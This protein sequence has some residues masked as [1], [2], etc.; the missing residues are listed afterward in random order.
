M[1]ANELFFLTRTD[2]KNI[3]EFRHCREQG[4]WKQGCRAFHWIRQHSLPRH[5]FLWQRSVQPCVQH[6]QSAHH[7]VGSNP[8]SWDVSKACHTWCSGAADVGGQ[9][10]C[11]RIWCVPGL[12]R[13]CTQGHCPP[14][15]IPVPL[16]PQKLH[17][18]QCVTLQPPGPVWDPNAPDVLPL[19]CEDDFWRW[20]APAHCRAARNTR[21][22]HWQFWSIRSYVHFFF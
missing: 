18:K 13:P 3:W 5:F 11:W 22:H 15:H 9:E 14:H 17:E 7:Q 12:L 20:V 8:G 16:D 19:H 10:E 4:K 2:F 1:T 21:N 6:F